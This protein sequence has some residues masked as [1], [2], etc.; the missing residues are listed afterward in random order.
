MP[1]GF[2]E[3]LGLLAFPAIK[4]AGYTAFAVYLN[5]TFPDNPRNI[6]AVGLSRTGIGLVFGTALALLSFP[7]V[8]VGG[9]GVVIYGLGLI[10]VRVLEWWIIIKAFYSF[11]SPLS[12]SELRRPVTLGVITS[13][14]LDIP[15]LTGLVYAASFWIC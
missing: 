8:L 15:A 10:P 13:F 2:S 14:L 1:G 9:I 11:D 3:P 7:F 12:W 4:A 5:R 6:F